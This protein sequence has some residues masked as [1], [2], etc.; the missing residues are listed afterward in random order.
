[1][2]DRFSC[3][4]NKLFIKFSYSCVSNDDFNGICFAKNGC[5]SGHGLR[6][7]HRARMCQRAFVFFI[8]ISTFYL[9]V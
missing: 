3:N 7:G 8:S 9:S 1:M 2:N 6:V 5:A 4:E